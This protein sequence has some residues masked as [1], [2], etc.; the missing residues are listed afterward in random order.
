MKAFVFVGGTIAAENIKL[1]KEEDD[2]V[3]AA[4]SG[5]L[6]AKALS[7]EPDLVVGDF[8]SL[9]RE[10]IPS[11]VKIVELPPEKDLTDTQVACDIAI[12]SGAREII[13]IGGLD[14]RLDHALSNMAI[15]RFLEKKKIR[16]SISD[17][18][19]RVRYIRNTNEIVVRSPYKY[20][21]LI[22]D[23]EVAKG[24]DIEGCKYP[25]ENAKLSREHQF[26]V[27]NEIVGNCALVSVKKGGLFIIESGY[28][29]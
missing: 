8:D 17:G 3:L 1:N 21:S 16:A 13:I 28:G 22:A 19:N 11:G 5:Y 7:F 14:G 29:E 15:L 18:R 25:L 10:N 24:V 9:G 12:E 23:D 6:N 4:D 20:L 2:I 27:S 26:A